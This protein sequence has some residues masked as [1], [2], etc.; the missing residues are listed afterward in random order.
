MEN[1]VHSV[2]TNYNVRQIKHEFCRKDESNKKVSFELCF[3]RLD[4]IL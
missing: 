4:F 2:Y 1:A 3:E